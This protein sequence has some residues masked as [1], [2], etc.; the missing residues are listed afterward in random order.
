[1]GIS[2]KQHEDRSGHEVPPDQRGDSGE[3]FRE[4]GIDEPK[5]GADTSDTSSS[6]SGTTT[7]SD[8]TP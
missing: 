6:D 3:N 1:M 4:G 2:D 5:S 7:Q 8:G